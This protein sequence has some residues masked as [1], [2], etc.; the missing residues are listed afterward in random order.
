[1]ASRNRTAG[2][3]Y[4][5]E[6]IDNF[7]KVGYPHTVSSRSEN[8]TRD[9]EKVDLC[10][11]NELKNGRLPFNVQCK[12]T[13]GKLS[14]KQVLGESNL[15][16]EKVLGEIELIEG[17]TNVVLNKKTKKSEKGRFIP[18]ERYAFLYEIDFFK[19]IEERNKFQ[20]AYEI[21]VDGFS[22]Y[23]RLSDDPQVNPDIENVFESLKHLEL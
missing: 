3:N 1:M 14:K 9:G 12:T 22:K 2:H 10:N 5:R 15:A 20:K 4:E 13:C 6:T 11:H 8:R 23:R 19:L 7:K 21:L 18:K 17:I 16:Y